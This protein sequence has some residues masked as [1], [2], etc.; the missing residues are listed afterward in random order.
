MRHATPADIPWITQLLK[1]GRGRGFMS[2]S[3]IHGFSKS[4]L[5]VVFTQEHLFFVPEN[6]DNQLILSVHD[7]DTRHGQARVQF[8][9]AT[10]SVEPRAFI[11][12][13]MQNYGIKRL[14]SYVFPDEEDEIRILSRLGFVKEAVFREHIF[15]A[16]GYSDIVV[17]GR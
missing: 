9:S 17:F 16:G 1:N 10:T 4:E 5:E 3:S 14:V 12:S 7:I 13:L 6:L 15:I 11:Y 8:C 2:L